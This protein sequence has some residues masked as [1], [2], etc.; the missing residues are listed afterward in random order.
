MLQVHEASSLIENLSASSTFE[1]LVQVNLFGHPFLTGTTLD[2]KLEL[3]DI[4]ALSNTSRQTV[5][6]TLTT[7]MKTKTKKG[8]L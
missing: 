8:D 1:A 3:E 7:T 2:S 5:T 6:L 4:Q